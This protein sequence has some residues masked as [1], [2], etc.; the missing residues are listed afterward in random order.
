MLACKYLYAYKINHTHSHTY[1][2]AAKI[3]KII[4]KIKKQSETNNKKII[5][6]FIKEAP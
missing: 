4:I 1:S 2:Y 5:K 6:V 3:D